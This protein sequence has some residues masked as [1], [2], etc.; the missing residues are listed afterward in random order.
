M[1]HIFYLIRQT[2][3]NII[4]DFKQ[5]VGYLI[6]AIVIALVG[7]FFYKRLRRQD[8]E[9][10]VPVVL[11]FIYLEV[12][13][14]LAFFSREA[15]S[16]NGIDL[17]L[18]G[19]WGTSAMEHAYFIENILMFI[20]FGFLLPLVVKRARKMIVCVGFG[21]AVSCMIELSQLV[22]QRGY[23]QL[24]D[25]VTN[26]MGTLAGWIVWMCLREYAVR[27]KVQRRRKKKN[28]K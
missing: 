2:G 5:P 25:V 26:T 21:F 14:E 27:R 24:D 16:R 9:V 17:D 19:T 22:T 18:F 28:K 8:A 12:I 23:C 15:G 13:V 1:C 3:E 11:L 7:V 6:P 4:Q 20:P 10:S